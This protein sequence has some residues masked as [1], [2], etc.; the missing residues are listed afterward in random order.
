MSEPDLPEAP[1]SP[2]KPP[3]KRRAR[4]II[5]TVAVTLL[6][7]LV[8]GDTMKSAASG[9][10]HAI[11]GDE[12]AEED[13]DGHD[14]YTCGMHPWVIVPR[15][16]LCPICHM[17]LEKLDPD[18][19]KAEI[20]IDP[21]ITQNMGVRVADVAKAPLTRTL[22]TVGTIDYDESLVRDV[23]LKV[24]GWLEKVAVDYLGAPVAVGDPLF[25]LYSP[26]LFSA[27][28]EYLSAKKRGTPELV[29][30][31]RTRLEFFDVGDDEI[32]ALEARGE[33]QKTMTIRS[34]WRGVVVE[35]NANEGKRVEPGTK[36]YRIADMSRVWVMA[37]LY[38][39]QL[40]YVAVG[41]A[42]VMS[43][44]YFPGMEFEGRVIYIYPTL[45]EKTREVKARVEFDNPELL[46][47]PGM[48]A[49]VEIRATLARDR[50]LV[51]REAVIDTGERQV[52]FVSL[53][54]GRFEPRDVRLGA[55]GEGGVVEILDG[56]EPGEHVVVSGQFMLDSEARMREGLA[57]ML[58]GDLASEQ[59][60][61]VAKAE[62]G[63][64][65]AL[66]E[67]ASAALG[68][69]LTAYFA[70]QNTLAG[71]SGDGVPEQAAR[72]AKAVDQMLATEVPDAP[73]FWH[74]HD[75]VATIRGE[76]LELA[77][78]IALPDA[79][80]AFADLSVALSK[81]VRATGVPPAV[82]AEVQELHCPMYREDQGGTLWLQVAGDVRNPYYGSQMLTCFDERA[83][84]PKAGASTEDADGGG[85]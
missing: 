44:P 6:V 61:T 83:S 76:A 16:G 68:E 71:D 7:V 29:A 50:V 17:Q 48:F 32:A 31:A 28:Q 13:G 49:N 53:G 84:L 27:Q 9:V 41:Q 58:R 15:P 67:P 75:E 2:P 35:K 80:L 38:E 81:L 40:P 22:R 26:E 60:A 43:L 24:A 36:L 20:A 34:R 77:K 19:F 52:A 37:S 3:A 11:F 1:A 18:K 33:P 70:I 23:N 56:L 46:L 47:K 12:H 78:G 8:V 45:D 73:H 51:P 21:V 54:E 62:V 65:T 72:I 5:I 69:L 57:K 10:W 39:Y 74:Q 55:E 79:R 59:D 82:S 64:L 25:D 30:A 4:T 14:Y 42:A 63:A 85:R 66:P